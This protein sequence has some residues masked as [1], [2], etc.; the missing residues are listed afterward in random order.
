M[1]NCDDKLPEGEQKEPS[2]WRLSNQLTA[3]AA[4]L[5]F[6]SDRAVAQASFLI[7]SIFG[8]ITLLA[9]VQQMINEASLLL[10]SLSLVPFLTFSYLGFYSLQRFGYYAVIADKLQQNLSSYT[11][12]FKVY[13]S[14]R[15]GG[16]DFHL[17]ADRQDQ[18]KQR[19]VL[20]RF[21]LGKFKETS[22][23]LYLAYLSLMTI[24]SYVVYFQRE[25]VFLHI[26]WGITIL[27]LGLLILNHA[28][29]RM[30]NS[31]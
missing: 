13:P 22:I 30:P 28:I 21:L 18:Q 6:Y 15:Q 19:L 24:L 8:L 12:E 7:A 14:K 5:D 10:L 25:N 2:H 23:G 17:F 4:L 11:G 27:S 9:M 29:K 31:S 20:R 16:I 3:Q 1:K 26:S